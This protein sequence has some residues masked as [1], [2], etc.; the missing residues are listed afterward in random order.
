M[1]FRLRLA[2]TIK[3]ISDRWWNFSGKIIRI[4]NA[5]RIVDEGGVFGRV[6][7]LILLAAEIGAAQDCGAE[8]STQK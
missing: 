2:K 5:S 6:C 4:D 3:I 7:K 8:A 1:A